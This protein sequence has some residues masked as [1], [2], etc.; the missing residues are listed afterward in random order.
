MIKA[1]R[2]TNGIQPLQVKPIGTHTL[3]GRHTQTAVGQAPAIVSSK[4]LQP[5][6]AYKRRATT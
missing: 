5:V 4:G 3:S 6:A 2:V 1:I